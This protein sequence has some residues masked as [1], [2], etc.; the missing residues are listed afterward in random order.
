MTRAKRVQNLAVSGDGERIAYVRNHKGTMEL[1]ICRLAGADLAGCSTVAG[2]TQHPADSR[3]HWQQFSGLDWSPDDDAL[4]FSWWRLHERRRDL[5]VWRP[6]EGVRRLT[7]SPA[8]EL[9]PAFGPDGMLYYSSDRTDIYNIHARRWPDGPTYQVSHVTT[10]LFDPRVTPDGKWLYASTYTE[11]GYELARL[12]RPERFVNPIDREDDNRRSSVTRRNYPDIDTSEFSYGEYKPG[13]WLAPLLM[14]PNI[15]AFTS[16]GGGAGVT[17]TG[18]EPVGHHA[19]TLNT[20]W[21]TG[22]ELTDYRFNTGVSYTYGGLPF[23]ITTALQYREYPRSRALFAESRYIPYIESEYGGDIRLG[24]PVP[25]IERSASASP[26]IGIRRTNFTGL[27]D[28]D[29]EPAD[30]EPRFPERDTIGRVGL[31]FNYSDLESYRQ[32]IT[33]ADGFSAYVGGNV[34]TSLVDGEFQNFFLNYGFRLY[35]PHPLFD[36]HFLHLR[37]DGGLGQSATGRP[38]YAIG[39]HTPQDVLTNLV[40]QQPRGQFVLRGY[41]PGYLV[42][43]QFQVWSGQ[44][45]FPI[46]RIESGLSTVPMFLERLKGAVFAD[47][48]TAFFGHLERSD[49]RAGIG[50]E[51]QLGLLAGYS[52]RSN[53]RVG[54]ARGLG[55][56]GRTQAYFLYGGGY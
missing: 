38:A 24:I 30:L 51:L 33:V 44:W 49:I 5:W 27:P 53:L 56:G 26:S 15:G 14:M 54:L 29:P 36:R 19:W 10:G 41:P 32:A 39:G 13:K 23:D 31:Q 7:D 28:T 12:R 45:R 34:R 8:Y 46:S 18:R 3:E 9:Q 40:L 35:E 11:Q 1:K 55:P 37:M 4:V 6:D 17:V 43:D 47:V 48:G 50:A 52:L 2:G 22:P 25:G 20:T 42:G 21:L 16:A